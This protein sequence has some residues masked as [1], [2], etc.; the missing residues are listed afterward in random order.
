MGNLQ[1]K[2]ESEKPESNSSA[3]STPKHDCGSSQS[4]GSQWQ[5]GP[6]L[7]GNK[8]SQESIANSRSDGSDSDVNEH[9][10]TI[11]LNS[12]TH[13]SRDVSNQLE[14]FRSISTIQTPKKYS[15][16]IDSDQI[17]SLQSILKRPT[18]EKRNIRVEVDEFV[19]SMQQAE[20]HRRNIRIEADQLEAIRTILHSFR[21]RKQ[22][23]RIGADNIESLRHILNSQAAK[24]QNIPRGL[25]PVGINERTLNRHYI[26]AYS[27]FDSKE[28][29]LDLSDPKKYKMRV[30][31]DET[32]SVG[33]KF[34]G[35][36]LN[37]RNIRIEFDKVDPFEAQIKRLSSDSY[38]LPQDLELGNS[39]E[40]SLDQQASN[41]YSDQRRSKQIEPGESLFYRERPRRF[42]IHGNEDQIAPEGCVSYRQTSRRRDILTE[43]DDLESAEYFLNKQRKNISR[44]TDHLDSC[45]PL[46]NESAYKQ[47][48]QRRSNEV[49]PMGYSVNSMR[50]NQRRGTDQLESQLPVLYREITNKTNAIRE[51]EP[52]GYR[53]NDNCR[54]MTREPERFE[55]VRPVL[56][57]PASPRDNIQNDPD[58]EPMGYTMNTA[59]PSRYSTGLDSGLQESTEYVLNRELANRQT[60][61]RGDQPEGEAALLYYR[62]NPKRYNAQRPLEELERDGPII[63]KQ[64]PNRHS[65][66]RE[67]DQ[68]ESPETT[69]YRVSPSRLKRADLEQL[70]PVGPVMYRSTANRYSIPRESDDVQ[71]IA[72]RNN[73]MS[74][75]Y[76]SRL[77]LEELEALKSSL[78]WRTR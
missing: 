43:L 46:L 38:Y 68:H 25:D 31:S 29:H 24:R 13:Q 40:P 51:D 62:S 76:K 18:S 17:E 16:Q 37:R 75:R 11:K 41:S 45:G 30:K 44:E 64:T 70:D 27:D 42:V 8:S 48:L 73:A 78:I 60:A 50:Y 33:S 63:Y 4:G 58:N 19:P 47:R 71:S 26:S 49:E 61:L 3:P 52:V 57:R 54:S 72:Y 7:I 34:G 67:S 53:L 15:I 55:T 32:E 20:P 36:A 69:A 1:D 77:T 5:L 9:I 12:P 2:P 59:I 74:N 66:H 6:V 10:H 21:P 14:E 35:P 56:Y 65:F 39:T 22:N 23:I 28:S